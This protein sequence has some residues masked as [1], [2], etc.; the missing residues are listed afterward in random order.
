MV[1]QSGASGSA[2]LVVV[3][4]QKADSAV[5]TPASVGGMQ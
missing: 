1:C 4:T 3:A 5:Y 2:Y